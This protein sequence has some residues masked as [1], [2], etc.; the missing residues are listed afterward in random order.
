VNRYVKQQT[1]SI[2]QF[3]ISQS[4]IMKFGI[5]KFG[6]MQFG[7]SATVVNRYV[8]HVCLGWP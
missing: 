1:V 4:G 2:R 3:G 5:M 6:I 8:Q 7:L